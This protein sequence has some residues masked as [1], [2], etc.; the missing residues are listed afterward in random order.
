MLVSRNFKKEVI[1]HMIL[2]HQFLAIVFSFALLFF[3]MHT[4][5]L[6]KTQ[7]EPELKQSLLAKDHIKLERSCLA[8]LQTEHEE[9]SLSK[10]VFELKP[11]CL[12][13]LQIQK[14]EPD[15]AELY[16]ESEQSWSEWT[17]EKLSYGF[18]R[19]R[20]VIENALLNAIIYSSTGIAYVYLFAPPELTKDNLRLKRGDYFINWLLYGAVR[21]GAVRLF[22]TIM[23]TKESID[24][25]SKASETLLSQIVRGVGEIST[26]TFL[27][28]CPGDTKKIVRA[29]VI[30]G[31]VFFTHSG[32][33]LSTQEI[34]SN[35]AVFESFTS[36]EYLPLACSVYR[37]SLKEFL[38]SLSGQNLDINQSA[39]ISATAN[40]VVGSLKKMNDFG[41]NTDESTTSSIIYSLIENVFMEF[42]APYV[43]ISLQNNMANRPKIVVPMVVVFLSYAASTDIFNVN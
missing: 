37:G 8:K 27:V 22:N 34:K 14:E 2:K 25:F 15:L 19:V 18:E 17:Q 10:V 39:R 12:S 24:V 1:N 13:K 36:K 5:T 42:L 43:T 31:A 20:Y 29:T 11:T 38:A 41:L 16:S 4:K 7:P 21:G 33:L 30:I 35:T 40:A 9:A 23:R 6:A 32:Y 3:S 26:M 28:L